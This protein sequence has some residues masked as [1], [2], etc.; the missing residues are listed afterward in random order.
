[1]DLEYRFRVWDH[2]V[3]IGHEVQTRTF[4]SFPVDV[5]VSGFVEITTQRTAPPWRLMGM[6]VG[7]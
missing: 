6:Q 2:F 5:L 4:G 3:W 1:M 7:L